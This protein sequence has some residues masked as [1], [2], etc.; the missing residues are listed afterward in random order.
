MAGGPAALAFCVCGVPLVRTVT[1][2]GP[3]WISG[4]AGSVRLNRHGFC[5]VAVVSHAGHAHMYRGFF[6]AAFADPSPRHVFIV[7]AHSGHSGL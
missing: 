2:I 1:P 4:L 7:T 6:P 5:V 3:S